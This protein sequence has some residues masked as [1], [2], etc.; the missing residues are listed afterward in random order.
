[1][2]SEV[3]STSLIE[4]VSAQGF[5]A[6]LISTFNCYFPF[7]EEVI[8]RRLVAAGCTHNVLMV[9]AKQCAEAFS[10]ED[11][12]PRRAGRDYT[13]IPVR[14]GGAF[15]PKIFL[16]VGKSKGTL[17]VGSHNMTLSGFGLN[18]ELTN[19]FAVQGASA[20]GAAAPF[21]QA[22]GFL[23]SFVPRLLPDVVEAFE[24]IKLG[25]PWLDGPMG[26]R[27]DDRVLLTSL[28]AGQDLWSQVLPFV[29]RG[30]SRALVCGP[31]FDSK[32]AFLRRL[33]EDVQPQKLYV[34]V[35]PESVELDPAEAAKLSGVTFVNVAGV[36][37]MENHRE[38]AAPYFHA[39]MLW[40]EGDGEE[41]LVSGSANPSVAAFLAPAPTRNAEALVVDQRAGAAAAIGVEALLSAPVVT[42]ANWTALEQRRAAAKASSDVTHPR[43]VMATP[44]AEGFRLQERLSGGVVFHAFGEEGGSLGDAITVD[45]AGGASIRA[46]ESIRAEALYLRGAAEGQE[47]LVLVHRTEEIS[48]NLGGDTRKALRQ[49]LGALEED[50]S[51]IDTLLKLTEKVIFDADDVVRSS[52]LRGPDTDS[53]TAETHGTGLESLAVD[54]AGRKVSKRRKSLASGDIVV[55]LDALIRRLGEGLEGVSAPPARNNEEA[56]VGADEE[57]GGDLANTSPNLEELARACRG[58]ARR[59]VTRMGRQLDEATEPDRARRAVVQFAAVLGVVRALRIVERRAEWRRKGLKLID[60]GDTWNLFEMGVLAIAWG[61]E[62]L[63]GRA[64]QETEGEWFE[65]LSQVLGLLGWLAWDVEIDIETSFARNGQ[66]GV[67][68]ET[69]YGAQL[70][71]AL[72]AWLSQDE[73]AWRL[74]EQSVARTPRYRMDA[75]RWIVVHMDLAEQL[76]SPAGSAEPEGKRGRQPF[77]GDLVI[78]SE[79]FDPRVRVIL[80]VEP[81]A[82]DMKVTFFD[83]DS[84]DGKRV[85]TASRVETIPWTGAGGLLLKAAS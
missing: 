12:R 59:L 85:F 71:A 51:Q 17:F 7:Y 32:L 40:F 60:A 47:L 49:A 14:T 26:I 30:V 9:D 45:D 75:E 76:A 39:K 2:G 67:E 62:A 15:H 31:F 25:V 22:M 68:E 1:M 46:S 78:L 36:P 4:E 8:L 37:Q 55:I 57:D 6:S 54:A 70:F 53:T 34:G 29:P 72:G 83:P 5:R 64:L 41:L 65:E 10:S 81:T 20:R 11:L 56:N 24:G 79:R 3:A 52:P 80:Q 63:A 73:D 50:P 35:D 42:E 84:E 21:R 61:R 58:K 48:K 74:A 28:T 44:T 82:G 43:V 19:A 13:L 77:A 16:R 38:G 18:D 69:W 23:A 66:R 27:K 33:L